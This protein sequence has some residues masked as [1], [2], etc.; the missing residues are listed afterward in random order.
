MWYKSMI[1]GLGVAAMLSVLGPTFDATSRV[2]AQAG[3]E[4]CDLGPQGQ[5]AFENDGDMTTCDAFEDEHDG[6]HEDAMAGGCTWE[7]DHYECFGGFAAL[8]EEVRTLMR[9]SDVAGLSR[10]AESGA[11]DVSFNA[12]RNAWQFFDC[13]GLVAGQVYVG[14]SPGRNS[15]Q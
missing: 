10:L 6:C 9:T 8:V 13:R 4:M 14:E 5:H 7:G 1:G 12:I 2:A 3:C 15:G 11:A